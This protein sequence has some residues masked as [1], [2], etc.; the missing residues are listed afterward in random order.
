[1]TEI[2]DAV[3]FLAERISYYQDHKNNGAIPFGA[4]YQVPADL[5]PTISHMMEAFSCGADVAK[6]ALID[7][8]RE[9]K[10]N[11]PEFM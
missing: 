7:L 4:H 11:D 2:I 10:R 8:Y 9:T 3:D 1:M 6:S 5:L